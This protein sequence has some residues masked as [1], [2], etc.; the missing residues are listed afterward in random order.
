LQSK[1]HK[2]M[3]N[4]IQQEQHWTEV[5]EPRRK[6]FDLRLD[7]V[8]KYKDLVILFVRRDFVAA[9]K[10]TILG[11]LWHIIQPLFTTIVF[12]VVFGK[13]A[14]ISTESIP[15]MLFYL[16]GITMWNYFS[17]SLLSISDTFLS[18]A[19]V[20]GKVYF[21]R[22]VVPVSTIISRIISLGIQFFLFMLFYAYFYFKGAPIHPNIYILIF[23]LLLLLLAL[24]ALGFGIIISS[25]TTKYRDLKLL[26]GFGIQLAMYATPIIYP[27]SF[28]SGTLKTL[29]MINPITPI[30]E[31]FKFGFLGVGT[32]S[33]GHLGY[34]AA[35]GLVI[36]FIGLLFV[37]IV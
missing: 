1:I 3:T 14:K 27:L 18:N 22:M 33:W 20:F 2:I 4:I 25:L 9:Y 36:F 37:Q 24:H 6:L 11:P 30:I 17:G 32:F 5:V 23:P 10:Q 31:A 12:T 7:E 13:I 34:S 16:A 35:V 28:V 15:P 19:G 8:W 21:P 29:I 26:L